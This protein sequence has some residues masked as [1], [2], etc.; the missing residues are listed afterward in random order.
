MPFFLSLSLTINAVMWFFYGLLL[1]DY[2]VA[3]SSIFIFKKKIT[4]YFSHFF[5]FGRYH[6]NFIFDNVEIILE[7]LN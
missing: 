3:V 7:K 1:R 5:L 4:S 6:F 2:Y